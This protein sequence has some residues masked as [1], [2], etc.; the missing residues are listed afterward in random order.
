MSPLLY[1]AGFKAIKGYRDDIVRRGGEPAYATFYQDYFAFASGGGK[2]HGKYRAEFKVIYDR[3]ANGN[4]LNHQFRK[5]INAGRRGLI[6]TIARPGVIP[7]FR[8]FDELFRHGFVRVHP[9][10]QYDFDRGYEK[11]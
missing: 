3:E 6:P 8:G 4:T 7:I 10:E 5:T 1:S 2:A 11:A 9:T